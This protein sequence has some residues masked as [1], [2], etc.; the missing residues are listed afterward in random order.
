MGSVRS[1]AEQFEHELKSKCLACKITY[2]KT[3]LTEGKFKYY[4]VIKTLDKT[5]IIHTLCALGYGID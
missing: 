1:Q 3:F 4:N 2:C 5:D